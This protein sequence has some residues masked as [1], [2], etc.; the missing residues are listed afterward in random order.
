MRDTVR[1]YTQGEDIFDRA[2]GQTVP[3]PQ[4]TLYE[5]KARVKTLAQATGEDRQA[6]DREVQ[7]RD[8]EVHL[9]WATPLAAGVRV[10]PGARIQVLASADS[11]MVGV[12]FWVTAAQFA[13]QAT[14]WRLNVE[15][16][17]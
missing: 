12:I 5:G 2:S 10:L 13:A 4:M 7:A 16:R 15:D 6:G 11:R 3:A 1:L 9:P 14:A 8:Y 17:S